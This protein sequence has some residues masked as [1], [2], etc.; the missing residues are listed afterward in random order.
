MGD[1]EL[2]KLILVVAA[3][4]L[5]AL[6]L[7]SGCGDDGG[8]LTEA[9]EHLDKGVEYAEQGR[10]DDAIAQFSEA[11]ELDPQFGWA[12]HNRGFTYFLLG[13]YQRAIDDFDE[14]IRLDPQDAE[15]RASRAL[16]YTGLGK[17]QEA[18]RDIEKAVELGID[19]DVLNE[20]IEGLKAQR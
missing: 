4:L 10:I 16:A 7:I 14:A 11:I 17:D 13:N 12:Y 8:G 3:L 2:K 6:P 1:A 19:A 15:T 20:L 9:E 5:V 18:E